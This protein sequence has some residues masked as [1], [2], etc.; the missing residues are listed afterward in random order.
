MDG[1]TQT[2]KQAFLKRIGCENIRE[3][4]SPETLEKLIRG[5]LEHIPFENLDVFDSGQIPQLKEDVLFEKIVERKRGGYCFELNTLFLCLLKTLNIPC[6]PIAVRVMWNREV[7]PPVTHMGILASLDE[8]L[9]YCD[10]GYGGP[11]PKG[12]L[13]LSRQVQ[14]VAGVAFRVLQTEDGDTRIE[15]RDGS[16]WKSILQFRDIPV[17]KIDFELM[18]FYCSKHPNVLFT[19]KRIVNICT[20]SG[21]KSLMDMELTI[22]EKEHTEKKVY[23]NS[24]ELQ[25]GLFNEF[26]ITID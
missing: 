5:H 19:Q 15:R 14:T 22:R 3:Q 4:P 7:L 12:L 25:T 1:L 20:P 13:Y 9:C 21:S 17:R 16:I 10:V 24:A 26:G 18:N 11:G 8:H 23:K 2:Q 6:Y